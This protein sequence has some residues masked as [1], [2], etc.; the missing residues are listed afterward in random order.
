L[1]IRVLLAHRGALPRR[2]LAALLDQERDIEVVG[3][4]SDSD[5]LLPSSA[6]TQPDII[7]L[8][9]GMVRAE[10][11][12][13]LDSLLS[14]LTGRRI[15]A[16][17][18]THQCAVIGQTAAGDAPVGFVAMEGSPATLVQAIRS[19]ADGKQF[20][21]PQLALAAVRAMAN[22][23]T[24]RELEVLRIAAD[25][26]P[27][28]EIAQRLFLAPGTVRNHLSR[29]MSKTGARTRIEAIRTARQAGWF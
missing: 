23:F 1:G 22:P 8:D 5:E 12:D 27:V 15:V 7:V 29:I 28:K 6:L 11:K 21:D 25:G 14:N 16:L 19:V 26:P 18:E 13:L 9:A 24:D 2:A 4:V 3:E 20:L 10:Q 17:V